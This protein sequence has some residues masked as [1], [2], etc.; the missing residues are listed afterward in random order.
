MI[1]LNVVPMGKP[2]MVRSDSWR[3]RPSVLKY[4]EYKDKLV[5]QA[6]L[7]NITIGDTLENIIFVLP[8]SKS[9]SNKKKELFNGKP[10]QEK[11]DIDNL[12]KAF[13]DCLCEED[14]NLHTLNNIKKVWGYE[15]HIILTS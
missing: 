15:G 8:M 9:W 14:K 5:E 12:V 11:P 10:H 6:E 2:R 13:L 3:K 1:V 7:H 4:W